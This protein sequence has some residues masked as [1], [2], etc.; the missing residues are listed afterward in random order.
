MELTKQRKISNNLRVWLN[1]L[2]EE[3]Y[4]DIRLEG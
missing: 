1:D 3:I 4:V 2:R